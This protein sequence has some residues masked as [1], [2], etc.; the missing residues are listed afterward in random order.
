MCIQLKAPARRSITGARAGAPTWC[1]C[2]P[3]TAGAHCCHSVWPRLA[4]GRGWRRAAGSR[5]APAAAGSPS[6]SPRGRSWWEEG[7][8]LVGVLWVWNAD[9]MLPF[10]GKHGTKVSR[11]DGIFFV[12]LHSFDDFIR[13]GVGIECWD[14]P[15]K[16]NQTFRIQNHPFWNK[17]KSANYL[18]CTSSNIPVAWIKYGQITVVKTPWAPMYSSSI[19]SASSNPTWKKTPQ[20]APNER[21]VFSV[22]IA[23]YS[24]FIRTAANLL[25]Q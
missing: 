1:C 3:R 5:P 13:H 15:K 7:E 20:N 16:N 21:L 22:P 14:P 12:L 8:G 9:K 24:R 18:E 17:A 25:E 2:C 6:C 4:F 23:P 11:D 19:R 10:D